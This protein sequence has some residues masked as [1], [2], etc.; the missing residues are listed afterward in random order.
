MATTGTDRIEKQILLHA[1]RPRVWRALADEVTR[2]VARRHVQEAQDREQDV[3]VVLAHPD[4]E[5]ERHR[6]RRAVAGDPELVADRLRRPAVR[7]LGALARIGRLARDRERG[8]DE[9]LVRRRERGR[10]QVCEPLR[11]GA[12]RW[13]VRAAGRGGALEPKGRLEVDGPRHPV[14]GHA[15]H[16]V[17]ELIALPAHAVIALGPAHREVVIEERLSA[18][19]VARD[20]HESLPEIPDRAGIRVPV[21]L[22]HAEHRALDTG[23]VR[24]AVQGWARSAASA[25]SASSSWGGPPGRSAVISSDQTVNFASRAFP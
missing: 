9:P 14:R 24:A 16:A 6:G 7:E 22:A 13:R 5:A 17:A 3:G 11:V 20:H 12:P 4:A 1:P 19:P 23:P 18:P 15:R 2:D 10:S 21:M 25:A 8:V